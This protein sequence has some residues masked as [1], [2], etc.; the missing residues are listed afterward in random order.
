MCL[1][2]V[3]CPV[4][5][6]EN[7]TDTHIAPSGMCSKQ[8]DCLVGHELFNGESSYVTTCLSDAAWAPVWDCRSECAVSSS[9]ELNDQL[10]YNT[11]MLALCDRLHQLHVLFG[12]SLP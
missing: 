11:N 2:E 3:G 5:I 10:Q 8:I 6:L 4:L 1:V 7:T 12:G 9:L